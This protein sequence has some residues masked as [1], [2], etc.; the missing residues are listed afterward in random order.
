MKEKS[1]SLKVS[2]KAEC[3][4]KEPLNAQTILPHLLNKVVV[5]LGMYG[6]Q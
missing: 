3:G 5:L 1:T 4:K 6:C 2:E